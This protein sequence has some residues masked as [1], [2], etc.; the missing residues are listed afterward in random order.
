[1]LTIQAKRAFEVNFLLK[2][3]GK[4]DF[5]EFGLFSFTL[6]TNQL[7]NTSHVFSLENVFIGHSVDNLSSDGQ[8]TGI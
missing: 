7:I 8:D 3:N 6:Q 2:Q 1:M 4:I 5:V